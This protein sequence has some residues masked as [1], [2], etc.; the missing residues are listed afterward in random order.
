MQFE[1]FFPSFLNICLGMVW[2]LMKCKN[3]RLF[4]PSNLSQK[5]NRYEISSSELRSFFEWQ[6]RELL[7]FSGWQFWPMFS[8]S[9]ITRLVHFSRTNV[10]KSINRFDFEWEC[11]FTH[12]LVL[13]L[14]SQSETTMKILH[15]CVRAHFV[16]V[17]VCVC[18]CDGVCR[19]RCVSNNKTTE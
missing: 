18:V 16:C 1:R 14:F 5:S 17:C 3:R 19:C 8:R 4:I 7:L 2:E 9:F 15:C 10:S 13:F 12:V 11:P 6:L